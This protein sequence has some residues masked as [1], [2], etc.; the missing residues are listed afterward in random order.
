MNRVANALSQR[1]H[2][3]SVIPFQTNLHE[4][5]LTLQR[6]DDWYKEVKDFI[7]QNKMMVPK[8]EGFTMDNGEFL[9]FKGQ[10]YIP[11]NEELRSLIINE[12]YRVGEG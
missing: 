6:D 4:N 1:P 10:I 5:I 9:T 8:F 11:P 7:R 2:I 12:A 3:F